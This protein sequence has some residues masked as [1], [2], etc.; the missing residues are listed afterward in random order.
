MAEVTGE[1]DQYGVPEIL[2]HLGRLSSA[3]REAGDVHQVL[4]SPDG[5]SQTFSVADELY[6]IEFNLRTHVAAIEAVL[7]R[8]ESMPGVSEST[9][10]LIHDFTTDARSA[11]RPAPTTAEPTQV[12]DEEGAGH[13]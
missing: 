7:A 5:V 3:L 2:D 8:W 11:M 12:P 9:A 1:S 13:E 10:D 4:L 6:L